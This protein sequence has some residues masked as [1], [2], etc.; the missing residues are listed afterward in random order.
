MQIDKAKD[1]D[2]VMPMYNLKEYSDIYSKI[3]R[4]F[5][6]FWIVEP[7]DDIT[8]SK[9]SLNSWTRLIIQVL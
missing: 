7:N 9:S 8:E 4:S 6:Q 1:L 5:Y 2:V 3:S